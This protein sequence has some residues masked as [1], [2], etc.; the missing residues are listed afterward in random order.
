M[1]V[2]LVTLALATVVGLVVRHRNGRFRSGRR[3]A[4]PALP[5]PGSRATFVQLS[6]ATCAVCPAVSRVLA[7]VATRT[8]GVEH[9][10]LR[11]EDHPELLRRYDIRRSPTVLLVDGAGRLHSRTSG[12]LTPAQASAALT[13][14]LEETYEPA[15]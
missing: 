1:T 4:A 14:L 6:A 13:A 2:L 15:A 8:P 7:D 9:V 10:E 12:A 3:E 5:A 11:A